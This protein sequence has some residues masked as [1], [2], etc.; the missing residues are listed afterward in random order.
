MRLIKEKSSSSK[1]FNFQV[2]I[3]NPVGK[4]LLAL[5]IL[6][7]VAFSAKGQI[8]TRQAGLWSDPNTWTGLNVPLPGDNVSIS[9]NVT[10]NISTTINDITIVAGVSSLTL[11]SASSFTFTVNGNFIL[12]GSCVI[13]AIS[14][15]WTLDLKGNFTIPALQTPNFTNVQIM[16]IASKDFIVD[17]TFKADYT[18]PTITLG[19]LK[20][21]NTGSW[22]PFAGISVTVNSLTITEG[23]IIDNPSSTAGQISVT[24]GF[25]VN[26]ATTFGQVSTLGNC[27][28]TVNGATTLDGVLNFSRTS[29]GTK[30]FIGTITVNSR[31]EFRNSLGESM[32]LNCSIVNNGTW[33][34]PA[35][36]SGIYTV[37]V[38]GSYS[39][40]GA[41]MIGMASLQINNS[42]SVMNTGKLSLSATSGFAM[43]VGTTSASFV[44]GTGGYL[45]VYTPLFHPLTNGGLV[46]G[47]DFH[48]YSN[49]VDYGYPGN[50]TIL[51]GSSIAVFNKLTISNSGTKSCT[52]NIQ[53]DVLLTTS[54]SAILY[55]VPVNHITGSAGITMT[56]TSQ[57]RYD[58]W[59]TTFPELTF[60]GSA[61]SI[62]PNT[63]IQLSTGGAGATL[64]PNSS[65]QYENILI[66]GPGVVDMSNVTRINGNLTLTGNGAISNIP[67]MT[68]GGTLTHSTFGSITT[69]LSNNLTVGN[70][71]IS[72]GTFDFNSKN[73]TINGNGGSLTQN[74]GSITNSGSTITITG[75]NGSWAKNGGSITNTGSTVIFTAG[76]GQKIA[77]SQAS[78]FPNLTID[79]P[80]NIILA[81][82]PTVT[83]TLTLTNGTI[84]T[85]SSYNMILAA[86]GIVSRTPSPTSCFV[87]GNFQK[88]FNSCGSACAA[89]ISFEIGS[90]N[91]YA[92]FQMLNSTFTVTSSTVSFTAF[93]IGTDHPQILT[94]LLSPSKS[95]HR[96][97]GLATS[98]ITGS[99][100]LTPVFTYASSD[101]DAVLANPSNFYFGRYNPGSFVWA[102]Q[103]FAGTVASTTFTSSNS[104]VL[105]IGDAQSREFQVGEPIA[106]TT[107]TV[108]N[109]V[110]G[111]ANWNSS[112]TWMKLMA[113]TLTA[114]GASNIVTGSGF[115]NLQ[116]IPGP[117]VLVDYSLNS[118]AEIGTVASIQNDN[119]LTLTGLASGNFSNV[120]YAIETIPTSTDGVTIALRLSASSVNVQV[121]AP[122]QCFSLIFASTGL[123][124]SVTHLGNS[125]TVSSTVTIQHPSVN[126][127]KN[128]WNIND[129]TASCALLTIGSAGG[130]GSTTIPIA[131]VVLTTGLLTLGNL[132]FNLVNVVNNEVSGILD[133][134]GTGE[135]RLGGTMTGV[136]G[137][138]KAPVSGTS[139]F[140]YNGT[141]AQTVAFPSTSAT[142]WVYS[143]IYSN[144]TSS[145]GLSLTGSNNLTPST[146]TG[147]L[148]IQ[149][150]SFTAASGRDIT[151]GLSRSFQIYPGAS[152]TIGNSL[153][154][155]GTVDAGPTHPFGTFIY[156]VIPTSGVSAL[157]YGNIQFIGSSSSY[158]LPAG[159]FLV[160]GSL[161]MAQT[162]ANPISLSSP[163]SGSVSLVVDNDLT[164]GSGT[165]F[166]NSGGTISG[167]SVGGNWTN[168]SS[169]TNVFTPITF[170]GANHSGAN[171]LISGSANETFT[172]VTI[173]TASSSQLV[174]LEKSMTIGS[175][176][177]LALNQGGLDLNTKTLYIT[178]SSTGAI[179]RSSG[180]IKSEAQTSPYAHVTWTTNAQTGP[181]VF[182][183][184]KSASEYI[185]LNITISSGGQPFG[186]TISAATYGTGSGN[187]PPPN[188][189]SLGINNGTNIVD[190]FWIITP[191]AYTT[192]PT[193]TITFNAT[194]SEVGSL[195]TLKAQRWN[196][197]YWDPS[198]P[199]AGSTATSASV[200]TTQYGIWAVS[201]GSSPLP[202]QLE[203]FQATALSSH[204]KLSWRTLSEL[205]NDY[206]IIERSTDGFSYEE[207]G[208]AKGN[209]IT[210]SAHDYELTDFSVPSGRIYYKL[211]QFDYDGKFAEY[212]VVAVEVKDFSEVT[213]APNPVVGTSNVFVPSD[214]NDKEVKVEIYN[215][216]GEV[217]AQSSFSK[218][219]SFKVTNEN[220]EPGIYFLRLIS[221][222]KT[223]ATKFLVSRDQP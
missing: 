63:T 111:A 31:G 190:R 68:I 130:N 189:T 41:N 164:L 181:Y 214:F 132:N 218:G 197:T 69:T 104:P 143:S 109:R 114:S 213:V 146:F 152:F 6:C 124:Q 85:T 86:G 157:T 177:T 39:Y 148:K 98:G 94:S 82:S 155:F 194:T 14:S 195:N 33:L 100:S 135:I 117:I 79:N 123:D 30:T 115:S 49:E 65:F 90:G 165:S 3:F 99:L 149:S 105:T 212:N 122:S 108:T 168:N 127:K 37:S 220:F 23:G 162:G 28:L 183:F 19:N 184:G 136:R 67:A 17:G 221:G 141:S 70:F 7:A 1:L 191:N 8:T 134:S 166:V 151:G 142:G 52:G 180:Y 121:N 54:G 64:K 158:V 208:Q 163:A 159:T 170:T 120:S 216:Q 211:K 126:G 203:S 36:N 171:Q 138:L 201:D 18:S 13:Q 140:N 46:S 131:Q 129:G 11:S 173:N 207:I 101:F 174:Q 88:K 145:S 110:F 10:I 210:N 78:T 222:S 73:M 167:V 175:T 96:Y 193:A 55:D 106:T 53:V 32:F 92:P 44:N 206:F 154:G 51:G 26:P 47:F 139:I 187:T 198:L 59:N 160:K 12:N 81:S 179:T 20:I 125:L 204:V 66:N 80:N 29:S 42:V 61:N 95:V 4:Y 25:T 202:I 2:T 199:P 188:G 71:L 21:G 205:N 118:G 72:G 102:G 219:G 93:T 89:T 48:T 34:A 169:F 9:H 200:S 128:S 91:A 172:N 153:T 113:G 186:A 119:Q 196:S 192:L 217:V 75:D 84:I 107:G 45:L 97:W 209:G 56:G 178:N 83:G 176:Y 62:G 74:G 38:A 40:S 35:N 223:V 5:I 185:P 43:Q 50:Q 215:S 133:N 161:T 15:S 22:S 103:A 156:P 76:A 137:T 77:G 57:I 116:G 60:T 147:D 144:N 150:G 112:T 182:P 87:D 16:Q 24:N 58:T 27:T